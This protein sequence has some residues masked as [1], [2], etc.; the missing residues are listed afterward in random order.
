MRIQK[1]CVFLERQ[2]VCPQTLILT[3]NQVT[4]AQCLAYDPCRI[5]WVE[6]FTNVLQYQDLGA[7]I[8]PWNRLAIA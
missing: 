6:A 2:V 7:I 3:G 4:S 5:E 1:T 8:D